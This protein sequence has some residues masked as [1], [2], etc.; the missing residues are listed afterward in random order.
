LERFEVRGYGLVLFEILV[1]LT[2]ENKGNLP[3]D[4]DRCRDLM[5]LD[6]DIWGIA[7]AVELLQKSSSNPDLVMGVKDG[8]IV[9]KHVRI[10]LDKPLR[11]V[12]WV[13]SQFISQNS[14]F[15]ANA[16]WEDFEVV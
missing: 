11:L 12:F 7:N 10:G 8:K 9:L 14:R 4:S 16:S 15:M 2:I 5:I 1:S 13:I 3:V 6:L